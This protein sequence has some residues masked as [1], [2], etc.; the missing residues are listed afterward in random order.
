MLEL[1][2]SHHALTLYPH[3]KPRYQ[4][5]QLIRFIHRACIFSLSS[6]RCRYS[7]LA[8]PGILSSPKMTSKQ[9]PMHSST[10]G[11]SGMFVKCQT[12]DEIVEDDD[13][14]RRLIQ[15]MAGWIISLKLKPE[16]RAS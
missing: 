9:E 12:C 4:G 7:K 11:G 8:Y 13:F 16:S 5:L 10:T 6:L 15:T 14:S 2:L 3:E 1:S